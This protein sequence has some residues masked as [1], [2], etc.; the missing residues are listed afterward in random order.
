MRHSDQKN[1]KIYRSSAGSGK[2]FTLVKEY[3][4][5]VLQT[6]KDSYFR[7]I[8]AITFT[9][10]AANEMKERILKN[11]SEFSNGDVNAEKSG[12]FALILEE[13]SLSPEAIRERSGKVLSQILHHYSDF[14]ISTIDS[15]LHRIIKT[16]SY[17]LALS[18]DTEVELNASL[19]IDKAVDALFEEA[20]ENQVLSDFL[21]DFITS[22]IDDDRSWRIKADIKK[23]AENIFV[24]DAVLN[25][26]QI[27]GIGLD[28]FLSLKH[29]LSTKNREILNQIKQHV[30]RQEELFEKHH[31]EAADFIKKSHSFATF[32]PALSKKIDQEFT[33]PKQALFESENWAHPSASSQTAQAIDLIR[34]ELEYLINDSLELAQRFKDNR[35]ILKNIHNI[36]LYHRL[37]THI[38]AV[39]LEQRCMHV[40]EFNERI[41]DLLKSEPVPYIYE[42]VGEKLNHY[43]IDEFQDTSKLQWYNLLPLLENSLA[44]GQFNM[45]VGDAKQSIYRFRNGDMMQFVNLPEVRNAWTSELMPSYPIFKDA[46]DEITLDKNFRSKKEIVEF[47]NELF[48]ILPQILKE[49]YRKVY[50]GH[51]QIPYKGS[52][53]YVEV[54]L[55]K[56]GDTDD[57]KALLYQESLRAIEEAIEDGYRLRDICILTRNNSEASF[58]ALNL[59][60]AGYQVLTEDSLKLLN[61]D[62]VACVVN[63]LKSLDYP[64]ELRHQAE[65]LRYLYKC[66]NEFKWQDALRSLLNKELNFA[67]LLAAYAYRFDWS[68]LKSMPRASQLVEICRVLNLPLGIETGLSQFAEI[69]QQF[70]RDLRYQHHEFFDFLESR[71]DGFKTTIKEAGDAIQITTIFKAK[72]LEFPVVI[73]PF[74][75]WDKK[76]EK[77]FKWTN[78]TSEISP[79]ESALISLSQTKDSRFNSLHTEEE[80]HWKADMVNLLYVATT[81]PTERLYMFSG[82]SSNR[83][84]YKELAPCLEQMSAWDHEASVLRLGKREQI[85][86]EKK[87]DASA[88]EQPFEIRKLLAWEEEFELSIPEGDVYLLDMEEPRN[89]GKILHQL[90]SE[91]K[92]IEQIEWELQRISKDFSW[93]N[94]Q[95]HDLAENLKKIAAVNQVG[96]FFDEKAKLFIE[97]DFRDAK[98]ELFRPDRLVEQQGKL[99]I[100]DFKT[101]AEKPADFKQMEYY[102]TE[103]ENIGYTVESAYLYYINNSKLIEC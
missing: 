62:A 27:E 77:N 60:E 25:D 70:D 42:R 33:A 9:K 32:L 71:G 6:E 36:A 67:D 40:S 2:T 55:F 86:Q 102:K 63:F 58:V 56:P 43:L 57:W 30:L 31:I 75:A 68:K 99:Q 15:F 54:K 94:E 65:A 44:K 14:R 88:P 18:N 7:H 46:A 39:K 4:K 91:A 84:F 13:C 52:G 74:T 97:R 100:L 76:T 8:C 47:N 45:V 90:L 21:L 89:R 10:K 5:L 37:K 96:V 17:E 103:L 53:A 69:C 81:R 35:V 73:L 29:E 19:L 85:V 26:R 38:H 41:S 1:F 98:G 101:G 82:C 12:M 20:K 16:F 78:K 24:E 48:E 59:N 34:P 79:L 3:L 51:R 87:T 61:N 64:K 50:D 49:D 23:F 93:T 11:L 28:D 66:H 83:F 72:G 22:N 95:Q 92:T 80:E